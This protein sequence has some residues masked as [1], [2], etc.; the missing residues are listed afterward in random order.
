MR[1]GAAL[2]ALLCVAYAPLPALGHE[3]RPAF[4]EVTSS[5]GRHFEV[6]WKVPMRGDAVLSIRPVFPARCRDR[7]PP[8]TRPVPAALVE[9]R[10]LDCGAEG[11]DGERIGI[12]GLSQTLT[13]VMVRVSLPDGRHWTRMLKPHDPSF[14]LSGRSSWTSVAGSYLRF[15]VE[16]IWFG[17][18][19][20]L[21]V[22]GLLLIVR[23]TRLLVETITAFTVA[24][25][26]TLAAATLGLASLPAAPVEA[27]IALSIVFLASELVRQGEGE[28]GLTERRPWIVAF[29]FGLL[30]GFGFAGALR[31]VG[32]PQADVP[33][34]LLFFN[35]G[36]E[37]G[38]LTFVAAVLVAV[39]G[40]RRA[41]GPQPAWGRRATAYG[42]GSIGAYWLVERMATVL[43]GR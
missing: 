15:G 40:L 7:V 10:H 38:Q 28:P 20:L 5:D 17:V 30:H 27:V 29:A 13:D 19:H 36:V 34:A 31:E 2:L 9:L 18:D 26:L 14:T 33:L 39:A 11:L 35:L 41:G 43:V 25:S 8:T 42:I 22:L 21:F 4:L 3:V 1:A 6:L 23:G 37:L 16:H 12:D 32:L 24:H